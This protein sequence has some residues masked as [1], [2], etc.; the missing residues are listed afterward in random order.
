[1]TRRT[2]VTAILAALT[3]LVILSP[4]ACKKTSGGTTD[5]DGGHVPKM[6]CKMNNQCWICPDE[7]A[8]KKCI[9]NP[10]T[11]GCKQASPDE[12]G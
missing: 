12:C 9:I 10:A 11:S 5:A 1:M 4:L 8:M 7:A 3:S 6:I 2:L